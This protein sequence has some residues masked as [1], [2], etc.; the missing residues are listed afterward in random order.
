MKKSIFAILLVMALVLTTM[1]ACVK[2]DAQATTS[3]SKIIGT[4][5][6]QIHTEATTTTEAEHECKVEYLNNC[7]YDSESP[8]LKMTSE[9]ISDYFAE[10]VRI[11]ETETLC[12]SCMKR[13]GHNFSDIW[14][15]NNSACDKAEFEAQAIAAFDNVFAQAIEQQ[16]PID[17]FNSWEE[18]PIV[19][20]LCKFYS[21]D[22]YLDFYYVGFPPIDELSEEDLT[23]VAKVFFAN[24]VFETNYWLATQILTRYSH[25]E[26]ADM[27][28]EHLID[29]SCCTDST[30]SRETTTYFTCLGIFSRY[31]EL[32][33]N[34]EK[35]TEIAENILQNDSYN[36]VEKYVYLCSDFE[37]ESDLD[38]IIC[39]VAFNSLLESA[40]NADE[41]TY[42]A[43]VK[44][45]VEL[46]RKYE[47]DF[48][49]VADL[50]GKYDI[51]LL[52]SYLM[53]WKEVSNTKLPSWY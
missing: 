50:C 43:I 7:E 1:T 4:I 32:L 9:E 48:E 12:W 2:S 28:W 39:D 38:T 20:I 49:E 30:L 22:N 16:I 19:E 27:S 24:P 37:S 14:R 23:K 45:A 3:E 10:M 13:I 17:Y 51:D 5:V 46:Y 29:L 6:E 8:I 53:D 42:E 44:V 15:L 25:G 41:E 34:T 47:L 36:F 21:S 35:V 31:P 11:S 33:Y 40:E 52:V 26:V 18:L